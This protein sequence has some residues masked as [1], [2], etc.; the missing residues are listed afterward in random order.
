MHDMTQGAKRTYRWRAAV[1]CVATFL[2]LVGAAL[3]TGCRTRSVEVEK[4]E[5]EAAPVRAAPAELE[6]ATV[7]LGNPTSLERKRSP[8]YFSYY[9]L[10]LSDGDALG[11]KLELRSSG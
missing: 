10:G 11:K 3:A 4:L 8:V 5:A 2:A 9:E 6:V 1:P 7:E